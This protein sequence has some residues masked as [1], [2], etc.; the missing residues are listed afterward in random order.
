MTNEEIIRNFR[1]NFLTKRIPA[2][3]K[4]EI[5]AILDEIMGCLNSAKEDEGRKIE[6]KAESLLKNKCDENIRW[7]DG[8]GRGIYDILTILRNKQ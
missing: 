7:C 1:K 5:E 3:N 6:E 8:Y 2:L 4:W